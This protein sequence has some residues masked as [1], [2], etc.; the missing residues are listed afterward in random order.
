MEPLKCDYSPLPDFITSKRAVLNPM[1]DDDRSFGHAIVYA[2]HP[3]DWGHNQFQ[4][5]HPD[6]FVQHGLDKIKYPVLVSDIPALEDQLNIRI[7][8]FTF[9]DSE[10]FKRHS[11]YISKKYKSD[12]INM[13][14]WE[15]RFAWIKFLSRLFCDVRKCVKPKEFI[16]F[17][18]L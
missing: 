1:N 15:G 14:Y 2:L 10:G 7:N 9:D 17:I 12:E 8:V 18:S 4:N 3:N 16:H 11:L 13:L 5:P 6:R